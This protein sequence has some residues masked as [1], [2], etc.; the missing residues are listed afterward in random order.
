MENKIPEI[1]FREFNEKSEENKFKKLA[2]VKSCKRIYKEE[3]FEI[4][5][6]PFYKIGTFGSKADSFI[7]REKYEEYKPKY[8]YPKHGDILLSASG[9][10]GRTVEFK[11]EESYFQDSNIIWLDVDMKIINNKFL[12]SLY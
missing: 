2:Y 11:G 5:D 10:L 9:T 4:G 6:I 7:T 12:K 3:T 8:A 1:R